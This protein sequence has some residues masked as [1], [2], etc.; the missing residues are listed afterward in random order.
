MF[1]W[2]NICLQVHAHGCENAI[3]IVGVKKIKKLFFL[4]PGTR[5]PDAAIKVIDMLEKNNNDNTKAK[6]ATGWIL[7]ELCDEKL[8]G[9]KSMES[10]ICWFS[11]SCIRLCF[12]LLNENCVSK[13]LA[14]TWCPISVST[15]DIHFNLWWK[16]SVI[17]SKGMF[18]SLY[19]NTLCTY[20]FK[21]DV[22]HMCQI[23]A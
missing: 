23:V 1:L 15:F 13:W 7:C 19:L 16:T 4:S 6:S 20:T 17:H 8:L 14:S 2:N 10:A 12:Y 3:L 22:G 21:F 9:R 18:V 11:P 5:I